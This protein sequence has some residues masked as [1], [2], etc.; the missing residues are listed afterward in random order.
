M[1]QDIRNGGL[2][3][4]DYIKEIK[5]FKKFQKEKYNITCFIFTYN[6]E[7]TIERAIKS[8]LEQ[9]TK[10][11]FLIRVINDASTDRTTEIV[12][13]Y[14]RK[15][16]EKIEM[17]LYEKNT[18]KKCI[19]AAFRGI[20][21]DYYSTLDGDDYWCDNLKIE[22]SLDYLESNK[23]VVMYIHD[24]LYI[25]KFKEESLMHDIIK[26]DKDFSNPFD[27]SNLINSHWSGRVYR[28]CIDFKKE[29]V[30]VRK[31]D[32]IM[33]EIYAS[34]GL[35]YYED[36]IMSCYDRTTN[37]VWT[38]QSV[39]QQQF[40]SLYRIYISCKIFH[41]KYDTIFIKKFNIKKISI[42][43]KIFPIRIAW[44]I[45]IYYYKYKFIKKEIKKIFKIYHDICKGHD[46]F[47]EEDIKTLQKLNNEI[48]G[49]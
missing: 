16:P 19:S 10:Y 39:F 21:T 6:Q 5:N 13:E 24:V 22:K 28:N 8:I 12:M 32:G 34:K 27:I 42:Y 23:N 4:L 20:S 37:G 15:Y 25:S 29:Y 44:I 46:L 7:N 11:E 43:K 45:W 1:Q 35:V 40:S 9:K 31:R 38:S 26:L 49:E 36:K 14:I 3:F 33:N 17:V 41:F 47:S 30:N 48:E 18:N 2:T